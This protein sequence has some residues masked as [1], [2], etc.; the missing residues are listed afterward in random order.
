MPFEAPAETPV[1]SQ[2]DA[3]RVICGV[4]GG[5]SDYITA[6]SLKEEVAPILPLGEITNEKPS[7]RIRSSYQRRIPHLER[8]KG[9]DTCGT[10]SNLVGNSKSILVEKREM[11]VVYDKT[12]S[13]LRECAR[14]EEPSQGNEVNRRTDGRKAVVAGDLFFRHTDK[15]PLIDPRKEYS[16]FSRIGYFGAKWEGD[17]RHTFGVA[18]EEDIT[19]PS[20]PPETVY[21][22][23]GSL[24]SSLSIHLTS[25]DSTQST[26]SHAHQNGQGSRKRIARANHRALFRLSSS[27]SQPNAR[28]LYGTS[29]L[30]HELPP[31]YP[32]GFGYGWYSESQRETALKYSGR[33]D[34][35]NDCYRVKLN[36]PDWAQFGHKKRRSLGKQIR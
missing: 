30:N 35:E 24:P 29:R 10:L 4:I 21:S 15:E 27:S 6:K 22:G 9:R 1:P 28:S 3:K 26:L 14:Q 13:D 7:S 17:D 12:D 8:G 25:T 2:S 20:H 33:S 32:D 19:A 11:Q 36:V 5:N 16:D 18:G 34:Y 31:F 23:T